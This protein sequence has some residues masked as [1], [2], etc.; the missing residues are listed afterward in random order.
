MMASISYHFSQ[1]QIQSGL[2]V[3]GKPHFDSKFH[4]HGKFWINLINLGYRIYPEYLHLL[5]Y[6]EYLHL[7]NL[8]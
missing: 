4:F 8:Y 2:E 3:S 6:T 7:F 1:G 5:P